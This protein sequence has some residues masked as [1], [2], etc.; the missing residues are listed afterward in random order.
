[1]HDAPISQIAATFSPFCMMC[2]SAFRLQSKLDDLHTRLPSPVLSTLKKLGENTPDP[3][4]PPQKQISAFFSRTETKTA[5][6]E[7]EEMS[8]LISPPLR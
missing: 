1:M 7:G 2:A 8:T 6:E 4:N 5:K 3:D